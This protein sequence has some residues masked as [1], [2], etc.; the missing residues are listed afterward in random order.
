MKRKI[1]SAMLASLVALASGRAAADGM[2]SVSLK[3]SPRTPIWSGYYVGAGIGYGHLIAENNYSDPTI[4]SS[5]KGEGAAGGLGTL[6]LGFDRQLRDSY[7]L[8]LFG[9]YDWSSIEITYEDTVTPEQKFRLRNAVS[10]GARA[11]YLITP[12]SLLF[13][14]GG[15]TWANGKSDGYF[16]IA[17]GIINYPGKSSVDFNGPFVGAGMETQL[18]ERLAL[19]GEARYVMFQDEIT[20][21][22]PSVPFTDRFHASLLTTRLAL[23]Y[24]FSRE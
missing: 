23:I 18:S 22:Q 11:G 24:K 10:L 4:S 2:P 1:A 17:S 8:G 19:R 13:V 15:Y 6:I 3:D 20:N 7:V 14:T 16:D 9:E 21:S 12:N 5:W